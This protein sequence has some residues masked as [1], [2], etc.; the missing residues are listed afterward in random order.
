MSFEAFFFREVI[1]DF[2]RRRL[3]RGYPSAGNLGGGAVAI[4][5]NEV[6]P[7]VSLSFYLGPNVPGPN[8]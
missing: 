3:K 4:S 5:N 6:G 2:L 1:G 8:D 7:M